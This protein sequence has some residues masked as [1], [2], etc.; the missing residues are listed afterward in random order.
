MNGTLEA[1][2]IRNNLAPVLPAAPILSPAAH[3]A[4]TRTTFDGIICFGGVD[5][6]YHNRGHYDLQMM[7]ELSG[8]IPV[9]YVN[10]IGMRLA[11]GG[12]P[13]QFWTRVR[14]KLASVTRGRVKVREDM[15]V[16]SPLS[17]PVRVGRSFLRRALAWQVR[18]AAQQLGIQRP[19]VWVACPPAAEVLDSLDPCAV[20]YQRTDRFEEYPA[21][22]RKRITALDHALKRRA[23]LT[24]FCS[25]LL[26]D[27]ER[28][29]CRHA[30][31]VDHGVDF[32]VFARAG[33]AAA[34]PTELQHVG[35]PRIGYVGNLEP[36][37]VDHRLLA[38]VA[39][40][41]ADFHFVIVGPGPLASEITSLPNVHRFPQQPYEQV[42]AFMAACDV[43]IMP[44]NENSWI[45]ACNPVKLKE[46]LAVGRP[47]VSTPFDELRHY[48]G[49]VRIASGV[50]EFAAN[51]RSAVESPDDP[52]VLRNRVREETWAAKAA[53][54]VTALGQQAIHY[55]RG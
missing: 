5:W 12:S 49:V 17:P 32:E 15:T 7:R 2:L 13:A 19:L 1:T 53:S 28:A 38:Q 18:S 37:R 50:D 22:D 4:G 35:S 42:P 34:T 20:I 36:H 24:L 46:Y 44:W 26:L 52:L 16:F 9:L 40:K 54:V 3:A 11:A 43:L 8:A 21:V 6:W 55:H 48:K 41:L 45:Q 30:M 23:E 14:R 31:L 27:E 10:S 29:D 25:S 47:V 33:I 39:R 51:I